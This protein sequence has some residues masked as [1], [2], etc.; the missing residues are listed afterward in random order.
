MAGKTPN[1]KTPGPD[2]AA[3]DALMK[4]VNESQA[5][6]PPS[7]VPPMTSPFARL[8]HAFFGPPTPPQVTP[9]PEQVFTGGTGGPD[10]M[11]PNPGP[12]AADD[13]RWGTYKRRY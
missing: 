13:P 3:V 4:I 11:L 10:V 6:A 12:V 5:A 9:Q 1:K 2:R 7:D 8:K